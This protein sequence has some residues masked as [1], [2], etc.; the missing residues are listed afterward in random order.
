MPFL[1]Q[2]LFTIQAGPQNWFYSDGSVAHLATG[3]DKLLFS[4]PQEKILTIRNYANTGF[5]NIVLEKWFYMKVEKIAAKLGT[6]PYIIINNMLLLTM[7]K[8]EDTAKQNQT[9]STSMT[10]RSWHIMK[11]AL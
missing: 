1:C 6:K 8:L 3:D 7:K 2:F 9:L 5:V 10:T 11:C 4:D